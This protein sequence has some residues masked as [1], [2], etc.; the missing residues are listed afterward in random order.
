M[1]RFLPRDLNTM[2]KKHILA[3][4]CAATAMTAACTGCGAAKMAATRDGAD[5]NTAR[6]AELEREL[7]AARRHAIEMEFDIAWL[8]ADLANIQSV[9]ELN[10]LL[11]EMDRVNKMPLRPAQKEALLNDY[12]AQVTRIRNAVIARDVKTAARCDSLM[13]IISGNQR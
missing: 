5:K 13:R 11:A 6:I 7:A 9:M 1:G 4:I 8:Q 10:A 12:A 2:N 3:K